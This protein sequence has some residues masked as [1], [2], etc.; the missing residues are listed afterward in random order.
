MFQMVGDSP[1]HSLSRRPCGSILFSIVMF[2]AVAGLG[3]SG[4]SAVMAQSKAN[5]LNPDSPGHFRVAHPARLMP[6]EAEDIYDHLIDDMVAAYRL[7]GLAAATAY[8]KWPRFNSVPY[9]SSMHGSRYVNNY[10]NMAGR[11]YGRFEQAK[12]FQVGAIV[13]KDSFSVD[14]EGDVWPGPLFLMEKMPA[15][16]RSD[17]GDW[18]YSMVMPDGSLF[19]VTGGENSANVEF[20]IG[21]HAQQEDQDHLFFLPE[22]YRRHR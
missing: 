21:C 16:F 14:D 22:R 17:S 20:C 4:T 15:G 5:P 10:A 7:S 13:A 8:R 2:L 18:R 11:D 19:G 6:E 12:R 1:Q 9:R 3:F